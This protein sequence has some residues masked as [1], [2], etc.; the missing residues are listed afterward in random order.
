MIRRRSVLFLQLPQLDNDTSASS[1]NLPMAAAYLEH[2]A[3]RSGEGHHHKF[4]RLDPALDRAS[5]PVL[6]D[7]IARRRPDV[8]AATLYLWNIEW[9]LRLLR[10]VRERV[11]GIRIVVGGPEVSREHPFLFRSKVPDFA[12]AGEGENVFPAILRALREGGAA[13]FTTVAA[14]RPGGYSWGR[15][16]P[17]PV[18][19]AEA[20]PPLSVAACGPDRNGMAYLETSRGCPMRCSYCRY[21]HLR[22]HVSF[23]PPQAIASRVAGLRDLGAR[24][25]R[26]V[27]PTFN[28]HPRFPEV[29][30]A[31]A[32]LN[33]GRTLRFFA[34]VMAGKL[35]PDQVRWMAAAN[36]AEVE[37]GMQSRDPAV[38][39]EIRRPT[40]LPRLGHGVRLLARRGIRVTLDIMYALP[41]QTAADVLGCLR[42]G[43]RQPRLN[44]QCLQ[45]LLLP[46]TEL[47]ARRQAW[48]LEAL[49]LPPYAV[50]ATPS[51][52][53]RDI[54]RIEA[55]IARHPQL[56]SDTPSHGFVGTRFPDLF[57]E[58][59]TLGATS[60]SVPPPPGRDNRRTY[61]IEGQDLFV[62]RAQIARLVSRLLRAEPD[63]LFQFVLKPR[64]EEP[65]D[66]LDVLIAAIR[67]AP[68]HLVDRYGGIQGNGRIASRRIRILLPRRRHF[69]RG[70]ISAAEDVLSGAFF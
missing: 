68:P 17:R 34:E 57:D 11:P 26:F 7:A 9:T 33:R 5:T 20:I 1:E 30:R 38:L 67:K 47:R 29:V 66:L 69:S 63:T 61:V 18:D 23:L 48:G 50:T 24:E 14:R 44:L 2:A 6:A 46:G 25:I 13:G 12:V 52:S 56:R 58:Q 43:L 59:V 54:Q 53:R 37:V 31:L 36:F 55:R 28:A 64:A 32:D 45:T 70:W 27:D 35:T 22:P 62:R 16:A 15:T 42:W 49:R 3:R 41:K 40:R 21:A 60:L 4:L 10:G 19:L 65:L 8:I 39:R 51:L